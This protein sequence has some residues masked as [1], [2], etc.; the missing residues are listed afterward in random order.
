MNVKEV[1]DAL[2][3]YIR[4]QTFPVAIRLYEKG[5]QL[6]EK[7][8]IPSRD[9]GTAIPICQAVALA[10]R[11]GWSVAIGKDDES[12]PHG[13]Y[14]LGFT[15][16]KSYRDGTS[17]VAAG[18]GS[19]EDVT[20]ITT[21]VTGLPYGKYTAMVAAPL[22]NSPFDPHIILLYGD[23]AQ[24]ARLI[25]GAFLATGKPVTTPV[26]GGVACGS[27]L[28]RTM[29]SDECQVVVSGAGDRF[30][31]LT[32]D[33]EMAFSIPYSKVE[34]VIKGLEK[35]HKSGWRFPTPSMF[36]FQEVLP[37]AYYKWTEILRKEEGA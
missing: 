33:H 30:F 15:S 10:R 11:Y 32:Q 35:G 28:A 34:M 8:R 19:L 1:N 22:Q 29:L 18:V 17:G 31:A 25:Q 24:I 5:E 16:G 37:P 6:P 3:L 26:F 2:N 7:V 12:C 27:Y 9:L 14:V 23:P 36:R 21:N 20:R 4:P 13:Y